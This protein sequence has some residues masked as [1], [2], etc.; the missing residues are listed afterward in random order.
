MKLIDKLWWRYVLKESK[1][2]I[3]IY[4]G[5]EKTAFERLY[6]LS[7]MKVYLLNK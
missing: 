1:E 5:V 3:E 4:E 7:R 6:R 2:G